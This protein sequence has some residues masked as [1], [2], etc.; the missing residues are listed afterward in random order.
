VVIDAFIVQL[1]FS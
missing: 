1:G